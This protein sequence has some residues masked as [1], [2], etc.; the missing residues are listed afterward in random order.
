MLG[1]ANP[2]ALQIGSPT[3]SAATVAETTDPA[4]PKPSAEPSERPAPTRSVTRTV[5]IGHDPLRV[6]QWAI[7]PQERPSPKTSAWHR[8]GVTMGQ[9]PS[10]TVSHRPQS[11]SFRSI[12]DLQHTVA[13]SVARH[14]ALSQ[15]A[16]SVKSWHSYHL[17]LPPLW[18]ILTFARPN[19]RLHSRDPWRLR[20]TWP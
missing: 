15:R 3:S 11:M 8:I 20:D 2:S 12:W 16:C 19:L 5:A 14:R 13:H 7:G 9:T 4:A 6:R 17:S 18:R 10:C 1:I